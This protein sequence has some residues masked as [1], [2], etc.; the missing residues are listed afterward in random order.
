MR[1]TLD[2]HGEGIWVE[3]SSGN[4]FA[5][6]GFEEPEL[7]MAKAQLSHKIA[8]EI[9]NRKLTQRAAAGLL[10]IDQPRV[11]LLVR[12]KT[13]H[14][15]LEKLIEFLERLCFEVRIEARPAPVASRGRV[16]VSV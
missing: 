10:G 6:L 9:A 5:D 1:P 2:N 7:E 13:G 16:L 14:F 11:S 3:P 12:G 15:S 4:V 8:S